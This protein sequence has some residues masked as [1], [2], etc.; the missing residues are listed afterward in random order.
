MHDQFDS[1]IWLESHRQF[2]DD[3]VRLLK[4]LKVVFCKMAEIH[5]RAPW[6]STA[7]NC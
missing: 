5:F 3:V 2:S 6:R 7:S 1:R 4:S